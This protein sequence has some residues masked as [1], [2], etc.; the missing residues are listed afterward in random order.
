MDRNK[1]PYIDVMYKDMLYSRIWYDYKTNEVE[2]EN[3]GDI[4]VLLPFGVCKTASIAD[5]E[6]FLE[7]R[8]FPKTRA[9]C[10]Q[11]L[12]DLGLSCYDPLSIVEVTHGVQNED[13]CWIR[14]PGETLKY[15]DVKFR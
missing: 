11:L 5:F 2:F 10:K 7:S 4:V 12:E 14:F 1:T 15:D 9:N 6:D 3:Y 13:F 8:C